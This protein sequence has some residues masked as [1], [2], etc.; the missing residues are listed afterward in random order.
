LVDEAL[1]RIP[2]AFQPYLSGV[3][4]TLEDWPSEALQQ[5]LGL[6]EDEVLYGLYTGH[7]MTEGPP[8]SGDL[9]PHIAIFRGPLLEDC[10]DE[11][12]LRDEIATT[13]IHEIAHH[14]GID[15]D[16]LEELGWG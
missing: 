10:E 4:V 14:F 11:E 12:D 2:E 1:A 13:V 9:P 15:E 5:D 8:Q 6:E 16:R 7:A 3:S